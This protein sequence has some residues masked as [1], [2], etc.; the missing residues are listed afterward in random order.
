MWDPQSLVNETGDSTIL[1]Y[2]LQWDQGT[3]AW[4][5]LTGYPSNSLATNY[6]VTTGV[7]AGTAYTF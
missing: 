2:R 6:T 1:S 4:T 5:D 7:T 3:G